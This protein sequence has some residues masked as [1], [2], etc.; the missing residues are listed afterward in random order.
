MHT[1]T[2]IINA[3][4]DCMSK[5]ITYAEGT[6]AS[7]ATFIFLSGDAMIIQSNIQFMCHYYSGGVYGKGGDIETQ[8]SF[9]G[10]N[11]KK[12][13]R[14][15]Y[16][17]FLSK[18][19]LKNLFKGQDFWFNDNELKQRLDAYVNFKR[20][21]IAKAVYEEE[22]DKYSQQL[23]ALA[24]ALEDMKQNPPTLERIRGL[25]TGE[26]HHNRDLCDDEPVPEPLKPGKK[27][28]SKKKSKK[29]KKLKI[30]KQEEFLQQYN[31]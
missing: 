22:C 7:A 21:K 16:E 3:M 25:I 8:I 24:S 26:V 5:I 30:K 18:K 9:Q 10:V 28:K 2:Q 20:E 1:T 13:F 31:K 23:D 4:K 27:K 15:V 29:K 11:N 17:G 6:V 19:E 12:L 14:I